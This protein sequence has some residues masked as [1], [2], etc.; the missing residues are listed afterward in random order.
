M[1]RVGYVEYAPA[2]L[3]LPIR[4]TARTGKFTCVFANT[5][6]EDTSLDP[7]KIK[8]QRAI[9][10]AYTID[11]IPV[12]ALYFRGLPLNHR[13]SADDNSR[14]SVSLYLTR[15]RKY[16]GHHADTGYKQVRFEVEPEQRLSASLPFHWEGPFSLPAQRGTSEGLTSYLP[17]AE[18]TWTHL[19]E[20]HQYL[21]IVNAQITRHLNSSLGIDT[22]LEACRG[23]FDHAMTAQDTHEE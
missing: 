15:E 6:Y 8:V 4:F 18:D 11:W 17:Y 16:V 7:L 23:L 9:E 1:A 3:K 20:I 21:Y 19:Q 2:H 5:Q 13:G 14:E 22:L 10:T 12:I